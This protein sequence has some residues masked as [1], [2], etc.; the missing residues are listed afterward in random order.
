MPKPPHLDTLNTEEQRLYS[1]LL[2]ESPATLRRKLISAAYKG[3]SWRRPTL[4]GNGFVHKVHKTKSTKQCGLVGQCTLEDPAD[5]SPHPKAKGGYPLIHRGKLQ[6]TG[7]ELGSNE[8]CHPCL[9]PLT[10]GNC[11][12]VESPTPLEKTGSRA[13]AVCL[14]GEPTGMGSHV[15]SLGYARPDSMGRGL[16]T[17]RSPTCPTPRPGSRREPQ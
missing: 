11:R 12:V 5:P 16:S 6:Y 17:R 2:T 13:L 3:Q 7:T 1:E 9:S 8:N 14:G 10:I 15:A 4:T